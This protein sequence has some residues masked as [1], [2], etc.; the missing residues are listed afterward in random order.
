MA[1]IA[2]LLF[3]SGTSRLA[4]ISGPRPAEAAV[5]PAGRTLQRPLPIGAEHRFALPLAAGDAVE[6]HAGQH[7]VDVVLRLRDPAQRPVASVD[8]PSRRLGTEVLLAVAP[9]AG[10]HQVVVSALPGEPVGRYT[11]HLAPPRPA[12]RRFRARAAAASSA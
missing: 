10:T 11:L 8:G 6:L 7:G 9:V 12:S 2:A 1:A 5:L 3:L 4:G